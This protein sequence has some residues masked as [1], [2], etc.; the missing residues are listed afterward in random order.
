MS[1][2]IQRSIQFTQKAQNYHGYDYDY[3]TLN[4]LR[5]RSLLSRLHANHSSTQHPNKDNVFT[6]IVF[7]NSMTMGRG[8]N[9]LSGQ[10]FS[11]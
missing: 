6:T 9:G 1:Q 10:A 2:I 4:L 3:A 5:F 11:P 7:G 8:V